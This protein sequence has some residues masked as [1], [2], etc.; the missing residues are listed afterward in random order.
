MPKV[1]GI[2]RTPEKRVKLHKITDMKI[3][4][5][6]VLVKIEEGT[7]HEAHIDTA[8]LFSFLKGYTAYKGGILPIS[9]ELEGVELNEIEIH[10]PKAE[11]M[12]KFFGFTEQEQE[13][14]AEV[15]EYNKRNNTSYDIYSFCEASKYIPEDQLDGLG[16]LKQIKR[17]YAEVKP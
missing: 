8:T 7:V 9:R 5:A 17:L 11:M 1:Q 4:R 16:R 14:L 2:L 6:V 13:D 3:I 15:Q 10:E 12:N